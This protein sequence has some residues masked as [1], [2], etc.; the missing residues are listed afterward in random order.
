MNEANTLNKKAEE[1]SLLSRY[2]KDLHEEHY[3]HPNKNTPNQINLRENRI[4]T[5]AKDVRKG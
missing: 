5:N 1:Q 4:E 3:D 2:M